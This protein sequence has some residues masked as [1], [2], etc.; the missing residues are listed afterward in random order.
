MDDAILRQV[1][2]MSHI[3]YRQFLVET[4]GFLKKNHIPESRQDEGLAKN[5][6]AQPTPQID[7]DIV[8]PGTRWEE[9]GLSVA[10]LPKRKGHFWQETR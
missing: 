8:K 7:A 2:A 3:R 4:L 1:G 10:L 9:V 5:N 6:A